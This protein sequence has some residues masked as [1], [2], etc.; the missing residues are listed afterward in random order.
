MAAVTV[1][2]VNQKGG[3]GKS[4]CTICTARAA[5]HYLGAR[6]L[7]VDM[8]PQGNATD[9]LARE[10][11]EPGVVTLADAITPGSDV[12]LREVIVPT[13][14][15]GVELAPGGPTLSVA[16]RHLVAADTGREHHLRDALAPV[17]GDYDLIL[18]DNPPTLLGQLMINS[19]TAADAA[20]LVTEA[21]KWS[22]DGLALLGR[23]IAGVRKYHNRDLRI[24]GTIVNK[25]RDT[26]SAARHLGE[27]TAGITRH[28]PG[29]EVWTENRIPLWVG[30]SD[31]IDDGIALDQA[32][33]RLKVLGEDTFRPI[34]ER[35]LKAAA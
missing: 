28:F 10:P 21:H 34:A 9:A 23:T 14:W 4:L 2:M 26:A 25:W 18:V 15:E 33:L 13:L 16:D 17:G 11:L 29:V 12:T 8:D 6:V 5:S 3:V 30:I 7:V 35:M 27:I 31:S 24:I 22:G 32:A 20:V 1:A 19:L